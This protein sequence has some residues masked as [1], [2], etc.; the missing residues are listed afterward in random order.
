MQCF[1]ELGKSRSDGK[2]HRRDTEQTELAS[3]RHED[4]RWRHSMSE[5][6]LDRR[7]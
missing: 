3:G 4:D 2:R 1:V 6:W 5:K 7:D